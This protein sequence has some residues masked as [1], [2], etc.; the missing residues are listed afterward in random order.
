MHSLE[1][2]QLLIG[3]TEL[4]ISKIEPLKNENMAKLCWKENENSWN[5]L[6][7]LEHLNLYGNYYLP[8]IET[9]IQNSEKE[10]LNI[11]YTSGFWGNYFAKS[12][13]PK[14]NLNKMKT[15]KSK[16]PL[17]AKL[18]KSVIDT[19]IN[20]QLKL[21]V[22]LNEAKEVNLNKVKIGITISKFLKLKLGDTFQFL[23]N[24]NIRHMTQIQNLLANM[25]KV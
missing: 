15:F 5:I 10:V 24:H 12:M 6:E 13:L 18:D 4:M 16:N 21:I 9:A 2:L 25:N 1:L 8:E 3:H 19:F 7:C 17:N 14:A 23:I 22:L 11:E 20:Q